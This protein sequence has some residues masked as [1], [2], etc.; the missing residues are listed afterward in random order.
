MLTPVIPNIAK[1]RE[2]MTETYRIF[3]IAISK[4]WTA[5]LR[6]SFLWMT[7]RGLNSL[8]TL[9]DLNTER[10]E[11]V[12]ILISDTITMKKSMMFQGFLRYDVL[13][14]IKNPV[15][16]ILLDYMVLTDFENSFSTEYK[17]CGHIY[18]LESITQI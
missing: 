13:P 11:S 9:I 1:N 7:L 6:P 2:A 5:T 17:C 15:A 14:L 4:A 10:F 18:N 3:G 16:T 8:K 12:T